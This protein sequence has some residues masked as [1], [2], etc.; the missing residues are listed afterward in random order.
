MWKT[1]FVFD[2][3]KNKILELSGGKRDD[4]GNKLFIGEPAQVN[5]DYVFDGIWQS[6][7]KEEAARYNQTPGQ[8]RVK[9]LDDNGIINANDRAIIGKRLPTWTGAI[10]NT[11]KYGDI[12][13]YILVYT[14]QGEQYNSSFDATLMNYNSPYN[15]VQV[16]YWTE[17]NPSQT[18]FQ[19]GN[20]GPYAGII[21][22]RTVNFVRVGNITLGYQL[23][24]SLINRIG[25]Q[26][27]RVYATATNPF[28][29]SKYEGFDPEWPSQNS[30]G[31]AIGS[32][33][34]LLGVNL[35]F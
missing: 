2:K 4:I 1:D 22:Y 9:D 10:G 6:D 21:N 29:F 24:K 32:A 27:L 28:T 8:V 13:L 3:N 19:P 34:Y 5:Y 16:D 23:P 20:P 18:H 7:E 30:Y 14:R 12:D 15:Q 26:N 25:L 35:S 31:T 33:S 11:F 17:N